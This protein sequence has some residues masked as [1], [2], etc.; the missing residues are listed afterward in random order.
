MTEVHLSFNQ[1][2]FSA[3]TL[4][5]SWQVSYLTLVYLKIHSACQTGFQS[6]AAAAERRERVFL[7]TED[8][9]VTQQKNKDRNADHE[10]GLIKCILKEKC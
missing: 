3:F 5:R 2:V 6:L 8:R 10:Y 7:L 1:Q 4:L 9:A